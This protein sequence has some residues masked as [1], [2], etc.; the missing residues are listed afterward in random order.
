MSRWS[1]EASS[2]QPHKAAVSCCRPA[3]LAGAFL[4]QSRAAYSGSSEGA[5]PRQEGPGLA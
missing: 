1:F 2:C 4:A 5:N 3:G